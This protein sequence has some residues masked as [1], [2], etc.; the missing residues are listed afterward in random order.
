MQRRVIANAL[1]ASALS[2][3]LVFGPQ[4]ELRVYLAVT[5]GVAAVLFSIQGM[6]GVGFVVAAMSMGVLL[7]YCEPHGIVVIVYALVMI[8]GVLRMGNVPAETQQ[9]E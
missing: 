6:G 1:F 5:V 3:A 4:E 8:G 2:L 9:R 7:R